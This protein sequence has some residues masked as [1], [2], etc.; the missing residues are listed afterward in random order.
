M[1]K[2]GQQHV[3]YSLTCMQQKKAPFP[4][5][6]RQFILV[7]CKIKNRRCNRT[8]KFTR[9]RKNTQ[10]FNMVMEGKVSSQ[11]GAFFGMDCSWIHHFLC[12]LNWKKSFVGT[13]WWFCRYELIKLKGNASMNSSDWKE[14]HGWSVT[15]Q[16]FFQ[17]ELNPMLKN[18]PWTC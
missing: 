11:P 15:L 7:E 17:N 2:K 4:I 18:Y 5:M 6:E 12:Y 9:D 1:Q 8:S 3:M 13:S 14:M 10:N 16:I